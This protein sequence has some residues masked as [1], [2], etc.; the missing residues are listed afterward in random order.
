LILQEEPTAVLL[1]SLILRIHYSDEQ[2]TTWTITPT[3]PDAQRTSYTVPIPWHTNHSF[4]ASLTGLW[5]L[6][7]RAIAHADELRAIYD[8]AWTLGEALGT[9]LTPADRTL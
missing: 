8:Q 9:V 7:R 2:R 5:D 1:P 6:S 4:A 3:Y